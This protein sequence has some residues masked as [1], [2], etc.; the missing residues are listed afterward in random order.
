[1]SSS[2]EIVFRRA[3]VPRRIRSPFM[4]RLAFLLV[5]FANLLAGSRL[6]SADTDQAKKQR[7]SRE[8]N[9]LHRDIVEEA[10]NGIIKVVSPEEAKTLH[11]A[12]IVYT[13]DETPMRFEA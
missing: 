5:L 10:W 7:L 4:T 13:I 11:E 9:E 1:M 6:A 8:F 3:V 2:A 12:R